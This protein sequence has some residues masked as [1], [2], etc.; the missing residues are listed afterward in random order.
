[1]TEGWAGLDSIWGLMIMSTSVVAMSA[2]GMRGVG[3]LLAGISALALAAPAAAQDAEVL[4]RLERLE[5]R[6]DALQAENA[7][8]R[9]QLEAEQVEDPAVIATATEGEAPAAT[10]QDAIPGEAPT[11]I[12]QASGPVDV[13]TEADDP[14]EM[15][16][17]G[18]ENF[19]GTN[20][21]YAFAMLDLSR[22]R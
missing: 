21:A 11:T 8:L 2:R 7:A 20:A 4:E 13:V 17:E 18:S 10:A 12:A 3:T 19:L 5:Q 1:M 9:A 16:V 14:R 6:L 22:P 15:Q